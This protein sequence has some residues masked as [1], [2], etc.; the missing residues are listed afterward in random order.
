MKKDNFKK[1][2][3]GLEVLM[4]LSNE[5]GQEFQ[6]NSAKSAGAFD[7][8]KAPATLETAKA[9]ASYDA[10][11]AAAA[12]DVQKGSPVYESAKAVASYHFQYNSEFNSSSIARSLEQIGY[13]IS[14]VKTKDRSRV[15]REVSEAI[16]NYSIVYSEKRNKPSTTPKTKK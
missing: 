3:R 2:A 1:I 16:L 6:L 5:M 15:L 14:F 7:V 11:K 10:A 12:F 8:Q 13:L 9:V 4:Q